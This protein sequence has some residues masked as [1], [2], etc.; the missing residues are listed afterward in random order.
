MGLMRSCGWRTDAIDLVGWY[1]ANRSHPVPWNGT[2][3]GFWTYSTH[4]NDTSQRWRL[5]DSL[6]A[7]CR[8]IREMSPNV[9]VERILSEAHERCARR[10]VM[11]QV[12]PHYGDNMRWPAIYGYRMLNDVLQRADDKIMN[13]DR[14]LFRVKRDGPK[15]VDT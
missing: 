15:W 5:Y 4:V 1:G 9:D 7:L 8:V 13:I 12:T 3:P 6:G 14:S 11:E 2:V 10:C